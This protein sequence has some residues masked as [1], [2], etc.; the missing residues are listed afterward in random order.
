[1]SIQHGLS[2]RE[3]NEIVVMLSKANPPIE[4]T[5]E[6]D[7][8]G[9]EVKWNIIVPKSDAPRAIALLQAQ[10]M[11]RRKEKG[12]KE[13]Y[14]QTGMIPTETQER[15]RLTM[16]LAGDLNR[17]LKHINGVLKA[18]VHIAMPKPKAIRRPGEKPLMPSS[19]VLMIIDPNEF[20]TRGMRT[21]LITEAQ[22]LVAGS[23]ERLEPKRV[24][25]VLREGGMS[26][27]MKSATPAAAGAAI[28]K[29]I[30]VRVVASDAMKL[31]AIIFGSFIAIGLLLIACLF[32][33]FRASSLKQQVNANN[34]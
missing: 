27:M 8:S 16:A 3:A 4:A 10:N 9:R 15:A 2:E 28:R 14:S 23:I 1:M 26:P 6:K 32:L 7:A 31:R 19:S 20:K 25:V 30:F 24:N 18:R 5:K 21:K 29:V 34:Y 13:L 17:T 11:P 22:K 12:L 33:F